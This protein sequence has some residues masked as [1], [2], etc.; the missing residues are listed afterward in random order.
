MTATITDGDGDPDSLTVNIGNSLVLEDDGPSISPGAA[1][2][3]L[4]VDEFNLSFNHTLS[5]VDAFT[6]AFGADG[7]A[8]AGS[9]SYSL[10]IN[11]GATGTGRYR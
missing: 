9:L 2:P 6:A 10:G 5:F 7:P 4:V 3:T 11:A 1:E 8:A